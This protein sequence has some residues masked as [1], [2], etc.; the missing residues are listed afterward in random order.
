MKILITGGS[1]FL[2]GNIIR[3]ADP[4]TEIISIDARAQKYSRKNLQSEVIDLTDIPGLI[5]I[6]EKYSPDAIIHTAAI[7]D[8]DYCEAHQDIAEEVNINVVIA[9]ADYCKKHEIK[10]I[11]FSSDS[12]FDGKKGNYIEEDKPMPLHYYGRTKAAGEQIVSEGLDRWNIIRPSLIMGLPVEDSGNSFLWKMIKELKTGN[13]VSFPAEEIRTP[14][15]AVTLSRAVLELTESDINGFFHL[16]GNTV[17]NRYEMALRICQF[18]KYDQNLVESKKPAVSSG[19]A[20]RPA[21]VTLDNSKAKKIL[22][23]PMITLEE[24]LELIVSK[25]GN[26]KI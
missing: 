25:K 1:G 2:G 21:D 10:M 17:V 26:M 15:D 23:T 18:L 12:V 7:S 19:R 20:P 16:S 3:E 8:I 24:G 22:T 9:I 13:T 11:H 14:V 6:L 5:Q 4:N